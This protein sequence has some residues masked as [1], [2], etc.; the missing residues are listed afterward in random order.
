VCCFQPTVLNVT[1]VDSPF[2]RAYARTASGSREES[3]TPAHPVGWH[4][5]A[6]RGVRQLAEGIDDPV[7]LIGRGGDGRGRTALGQCVARHPFG[8]QGSIQ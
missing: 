8:V 3:E 7:G 4:S 5:G 1:Y 2:A 6:E